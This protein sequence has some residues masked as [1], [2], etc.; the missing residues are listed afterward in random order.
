MEMENLI[1]RFEEGKGDTVKDNDA[2]PVDDCCPICFGDFTVPCKADCGHWYCANCI[3]QEREVTDVLK[4]IVRY[5]LL[6]VGGARGLVQK[7]RELPLFIK[8]MF[9]EMMDPDRNDAYLHE[10]RLFAMILSTL[11]AATPFN[12]IPTGS[13]GIVR[14]FDYTAI[15]LVI[16][17]R[18]VGMYRR[19]RLT[20]RVRQLAAAQPLDE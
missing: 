18:L 19:R 1:D 12:F 2:P 17:L 9:G 8:R 13:L 15:S 5:N 11:Y 7:V 4:D 20:Q 6:F 3:M 16:I 14:V 10:M